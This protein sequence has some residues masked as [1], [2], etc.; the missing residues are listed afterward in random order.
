MA[1]TDPVRAIDDYNSVASYV[2]EAGESKAHTYHWIHTLNA[3]GQVATG[4][5]ALTANHPSAMAFENNGVI[6]YVVYNYS[7]SPLIVTYSDGQQVTAAASQ[8]TVV[9]SQ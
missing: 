2:P 3:L 6:T 4:T 9:T 5:G 1:M 7:D 8:F